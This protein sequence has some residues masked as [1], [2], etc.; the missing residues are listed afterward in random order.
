M[1]KIREDTLKSRHLLN[2]R[3]G[4]SLKLQEILIKEPYKN[5]FSDLKH[6][7]I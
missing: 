3:T 7:I 2:Y 4:Y 6:E 1:D 5:N